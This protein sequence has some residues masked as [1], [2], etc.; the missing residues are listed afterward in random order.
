MVHILPNGKKKR[1]KSWAI[2]K[3]DN[4]NCKIYS[5][6]FPVEALNDKITDYGNKNILIDQTIFKISLIYSAPWTEFKLHPY[7]KNLKKIKTISINNI[8][9]LC[10]LNYVVSWQV[11]TGCAGSLDSLQMSS[12]ETSVN[13]GVDNGLPNNKKKNFKIFFKNFVENFFLINYI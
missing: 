4:V 1:K 2:M 7:L 5:F 6:F 3:L 13:L 8:K 9:L 11:P 12:W 10:T